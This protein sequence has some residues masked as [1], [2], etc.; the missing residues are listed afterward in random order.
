L[1]GR[2]VLNLV[3]LVP[4]VVP[5]GQ[6]MGNP[7]NTNI[8]AWGNYQIGGGIGNQ[9]AAFLDGA[10]INTSYN[11]AVMLVPTQDAIQEFRVQTN[12]LGAEF[13]R[14]AGGV[15][16]MSSKSGTNSFHGSAYEFL[17]NKVLN[18]NTFFN[19]R[20]GIATP[21]FT[22]NQYGANLGGPVVKD[23]TF[24]FFS[25]EGFRLRQGQSVLR[26]VP[27]DAMRAGDFSNTRT[28][29]GALIPIY[30]PLTTCGVLGN[31]ACTGTANIRQPFPNNMIPA[32][33]FDPT[34][35]V[36]RSL[37]AEPNLPGQPFTLISNF[38]ANASTGGNNDQ[39]NARVDHSVSDKQRLFARYTAWTDLN[40]P[41][42][43][44]Q[45]KTGIATNFSTQQAVLGDTYTF[46]PTT[47]GDLRLAF[48]RFT[49]H[50]FPQT[51]GVDLT[52]FAWPAYLN[53]QVAYREAPMPCVQGFSDFCTAVTSIDANNNYSLSPSLT[54]IAGRHT[55]KFG[56]ELRRMQFNFGKSNQ[57][58][59]VFNFDNVFTAVNPFAPAGTGYGFASFLLGYGA[60][61]NILTAGSGNP[62]GIITPALTAS[63]LYYQGYYV[64]D[65]FQLSSKLTLNYG[66]R[67]DLPSPYTERYDRASVWQPSALSPLAQATGLPL[68]G[69]LAVVNSPD[70]PER[71]GQDKHWKLFAPRLGFAYHLTSKSVIRGGYGIFFLPND[72][73]FSIAPFAHPVNMIMTPWVT[74]LDGSVT[75][76]ATLSNP[77]PTGIL[78]PPGHSSSFQ[79]IL[80]GQTISSPVA[81]DAYGYAQQWN[82]SVQ[83]QLSD[84]FLF[85]LAYAGSRGVHL[86]QS[87]QQVDQLPDQ[88]LSLGSKLQQQVPNPFYGLISTG[89]LAAPMVA[90]GQLLRPYPQ[91]NGVSIIGTANGNTI[92]H[93]MQMKLEKRFR[94]GGTVVAAY[95]WSKIISDTDTVTGWL[96]ATGTFQ[97]FNN[98]HAER[99]L[100]GTDV[101]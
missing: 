68:V 96:D 27:S 64:A 91:Y 62:N 13:G 16:N 88:Y 4:G 70:R 5:Q 80:E 100:L 46:S 84:G 49:F 54:K 71:G 92:Y 74:T 44:Y 33:R 3:A 1:N 47:V 38:A 95:T 50:S 10:P 22:Q 75:P 73:Y 19:N 12:N 58:S 43:P 31:A 85:E 48:F 78:Q 24:F 94:A 67:W 86:M 76:M 56:G 37:W 14:F 2:N 35:K 11:N 57:P 90:E 52:T 93:S 65:T 17:R 15:I 32:S 26:N 23:K 59:G 98:R 9:S 18:A 8:S 55:L 66:L 25:Y 69:K 83:H 6:S 79:S 7:T 20:S 99:S 39:Y 30:D 41:S 36:L 63:Q 34:A 21:A 89:T 81:S 72:A 53:S 97:D 101:P 28:A 40:L 29:Q 87:S 82:F 61:G 45:T 51:F 60:T 77:F 42:D